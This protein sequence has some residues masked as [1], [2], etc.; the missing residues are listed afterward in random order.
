MAK[1]KSIKNH[2]TLI[3]I[4]QSFRD[5]EEICKSFALTVFFGVK[6]FRLKVQCV[7]SGRNVI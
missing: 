1:K 3:K 4:L 7:R 2:I 6:S 5:L